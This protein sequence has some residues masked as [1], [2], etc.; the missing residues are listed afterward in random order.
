MSETERPR[1]YWEHCWIVVALYNLRRKDMTY[2]APLPVALY[3][4]LALRQQGM[5]CWL[6]RRVKG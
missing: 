4:M 1:P 5:S 3:E 2:P 6:E